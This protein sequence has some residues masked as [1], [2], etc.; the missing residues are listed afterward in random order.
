VIALLDNIV[1]RGAPI[2]ANRTLA[3]I[4]RMF[5][6]ALSRDIVAASPC[7]TVK[8]PAK[9]R[10]RDRMLGADEIA[11]FWRALDNPKLAISS[12]IRL[13][14]KLQLVTAQRKG[15]FDLDERVWTIP[16]AKAKNG[17]PHRVPLSPLALTVLANVASSGRAAN[18]D[19]EQDVPRWLFPSPRIGKP[20]TSPAVDHAMRGNRGAL[21]TSDATPHDLRRTA[22]SHMTSIGISRLVVSKILNHA[23]PGVTA[24]YDRHSYDAEKRAA[25]AA[26]GARLEEII[27]TR[28]ECANLVRMRA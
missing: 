4:R 10:R 7:V 13:V 26:W 9:E 25:L 24:V 28:A 18:I 2:A 11:A 21:G 1:D 17:M 27:G 15:E 5:G 12:A 14:L 16:A 23:E 8:A 20:I 3:V 6:W 22:A 19:T